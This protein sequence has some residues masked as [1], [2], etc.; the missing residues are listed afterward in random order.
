MLLVLLFPAAQDSK[1][2]SE[3]HFSP[4][5]NNRAEPGK[6]FQKAPLRKRQRNKTPLADLEPFSS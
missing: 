2:A 1:Q 3:S 5:V 6:L 4:L